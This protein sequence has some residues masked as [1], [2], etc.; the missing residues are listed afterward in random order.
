V[1]VSKPPQGPNAGPRPR[2][3]ELNCIQIS[4]Q[5]TPAD[6]EDR[7]DVFRRYLLTDMANAKIRSALLSIDPTKDI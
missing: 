1:A 3:R 7:N 5:Q 6:E 2:K 4:T